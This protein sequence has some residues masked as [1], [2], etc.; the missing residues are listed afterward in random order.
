MATGELTMEN[1]ESALL[2]QLISEAR[3]ID[4]DEVRKNLATP[5]AS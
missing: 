5:A 2:E 1:F 3:E 4:M